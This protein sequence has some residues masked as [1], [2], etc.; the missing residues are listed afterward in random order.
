MAYQNGRKKRENGFLA[1]PFLF[2]RSDTAIR[3]Q[4]IYQIY[5][6]WTAPVKRKKA[7]NENCGHLRKIDQ[8]GKKLEMYVRLRPPLMNLKLLTDNEKRINSKKPK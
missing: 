5:P 6:A 4:K 2:I 7:L 8:I 1:L 3:E